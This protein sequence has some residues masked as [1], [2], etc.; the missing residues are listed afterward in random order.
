[1]LELPSADDLAVYLGVGV[2]LVTMVL[3]VVGSYLE[4]SIEPKG[5]KVRGVEDGILTEDD[6]PG[7]G[8]R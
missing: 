5:R 6:L 7:G 3:M 8:W 2:F 1:M 4:D